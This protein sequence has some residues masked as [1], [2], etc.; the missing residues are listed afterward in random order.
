MPS[1]IQ[2]VLDEL[3]ITLDGTYERILQGVP[4]E[5]SQHATR[6]FQCM[7]AARRPLRVEEL[8]EIFA[9]DFGP[10][11]ANLMEGWRPEISEEA[12]LSTCSA[13]ITIIDDEGSKI[14][15]FSHFSVKEFLTSDR[16][17][18]S[19]VGN[20]CQYYIPLELAHT[21]FARACLTVILQLGENEDEERFRALP[22]ASYATQN[23]L[24]HT[25]FE[26]VESRIQDSLIYPF[27][28]QKPHFMPWA[29]MQDGVGL[30]STHS[31]EVRSEPD[32]VT[33]LYCAALC[34]FSG[35][36][37][38]LI[39]VHAEDVN[40]KCGQRKSPLHA[41][42][43]LG[44]VDSARVL[45]DHGADLDTRDLWN[46]TPLHFASEHGHLEVA[47]LLVDHG[48]NLNAGAADHSTPLYLASKSGHIEIVRLLLEHGADVNT[49]GEWDVTPFQ[50][51]T[52]LRRDDVGEL[53]LEHSTETG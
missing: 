45:L 27:D 4:K 21:I 50:I 14:V 9:I 22:L 7:V 36:V 15:Q 2:K 39:L 12:V 53:L 1:G 34:G 46:W 6:L 3:P 33:R 11:I 44:H 35:L 20:I 47:R 52:M 10:T 51:A 30:F 23:W 37:K 29:S 8:A 31:N 25:L 26:G 49:R 38:H 42:S 24:M 28:P 40:T 5:K 32:K 16:L 17:Q 19:D 43:C 13:L 48:A 41:A 18:M